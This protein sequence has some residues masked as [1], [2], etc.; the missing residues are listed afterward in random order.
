MTSGLPNSRLIKLMVNFR[1]LLLAFIFIAC[2]KSK[3]VQETG[4]YKGPIME[5]NNVSMAYS[6]S[7]RTAVKM[8]T[9]KRLDLLNED[10]NFPK[11]IYL[12]F[13]DKAGNQTSTLRGD[14]AYY[15]KA[16]NLYKITGNVVLINNARHE[17]LTT[18]ELNWT[19]EGRKIYTDKAISIESE[20]EILKGVGL[21]AAQDFSTYSARKISGIVS[22]NE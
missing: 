4:I 19:P 16:T 2:E 9:A 22:V 18:P 8:T 10:Q 15:F 6:D 17:T 5:T 20:T 3:P 21:D 14:S 13:F 12:T 11:A 7:G 1:F